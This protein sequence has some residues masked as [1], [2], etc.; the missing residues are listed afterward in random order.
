[1]IADEIGDEN[2]AVL[3]F[4]NALKKFRTAMNL[5]AKAQSTIETEVPACKRFIAK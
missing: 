1:M 2:K 4:F 3:D 5:P